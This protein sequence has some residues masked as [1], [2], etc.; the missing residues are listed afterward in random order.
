M[1]DFT[2]PTLRRR[3]YAGPTYTFDHSTLGP[4]TGRLIKDSPHFPGISVVQFRS[5]PYAQ[6]AKRFAP[7]VPFTS[8]PE[9]FDKRPHRDFTQCG[10]ACPQPNAED[11][12]WYSGYGGPLADDCF[13]FD[14]F[15]CLALTISVPE[16]QLST[17]AA[18]RMTFQKLPVLAYIHGGGLQEGLSHVDGFHDNAPLAA[19]SSTLNLPLIT[20]NIGYRLN[21]FGSLVCSDMI[22]EYHKDPSVSPHGPFNLGLQDQRAAFA[23]IQRFIGGFGGN[24]EDVTAFGDSAGGISLC[25]HTCGSPNRLFKRAIFQSGTIFGSASFHSK[26][27][28]YQKMLE[29]FNI[30]DSTASGRLQRLRQIPAKELCMYRSTHIYLF[31]EEH[32]QLK[33]ENPL[34]PRGTPTYLKQM[35]L[36]PSCPWLEDVIIGDDFWEGYVF[37]HLAKAIVPVDFVGGIYAMFPEK[38]ARDLLAA[39][40]LPTSVQSAIR[41]DR[42]L[43]WHILTYF[44]G[45]LLLSAPT[46]KLANSLASH[47]LAN[48]KQRKIYRYIFGP[49]NPF[50]FGDHAFVVG[51]HFL[52]ITF[53]FLTLLDRYPRHRDRWLEKQA[54]KTAQQWILFANGKA[55]WPEYE[56]QDEGGSGAKVAVCDDIRGWHVKTVAE[57]EQESQEDPWGP[58]RYAGFTAIEAAYEALREPGMEDDAWADKVHTVRRLLLGRNG[59]S[60][61]SSTSSQN[62]S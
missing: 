27:A 36:I 42:N 10:F 54:K 44:Y 2:Q 24:G 38:Q 23:W 28:E 59:S 62:E 45:D 21:W 8:I 43:F 17:V 46:Q 4:L 55:P 14:E 51:H 12:S 32:P 40:D 34:F 56:I 18:N 52:E 58:R 6:V 31:V 29:H 39:Y 7:C 37:R 35:E 5:I 50:A 16:T 48:G 53:L 26:E 41:E 9:V 1:G 22:D 3:I 60:S 25:Y 33:L 47:S 13:E 20:V 61:T 11:P 30:K 19:Y 15:S 57:D 49:S